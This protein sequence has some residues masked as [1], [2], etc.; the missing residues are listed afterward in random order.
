MHKSDT[1]SHIEQDI[2]LLRAG[3]EMTILFA[4]SDKIDER[5]L[6]YS[7]KASFADVC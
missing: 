4:M 1:G 3:V 2:I 5:K 7:A 6:W